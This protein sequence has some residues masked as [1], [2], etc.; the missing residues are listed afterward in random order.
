MLNF[1]LSLSSIEDLLIKVTL[2]L[3][4]LLPELLSELD[5]LVEHIPHIGHPI[6]MILLGFLLL[7][8]VEFLAK[9]LD[10]TPLI[11]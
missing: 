3:L 8:L 4:L 1:Q 7:F 10:F 5:L 11:S 2:L 6:G 9:L